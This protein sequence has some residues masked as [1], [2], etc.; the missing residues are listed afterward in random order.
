MR[1]VSA[2]RK[3]ESQAWQFEYL[4]LKAEDEARN[5]DDNLKQRKEYFDN[6]NWS[7]KDFSSAWFL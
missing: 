6:R 7:T 4:V 3:H 5:D 1:L 2:D